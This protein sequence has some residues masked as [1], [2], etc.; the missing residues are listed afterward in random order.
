MGA[1]WAHALPAYFDKWGVAYILCKD[2]EKISR[3]SGGFDAVQGVICHHDAIGPA[4]GEDTWRSSIPPRFGGNRAD[5][6]VGNGCLDH[7]GVFH[8]WAAGAA[9]TAGK[10]GPMLSSRG[11]IA[12]DN[13]N[14]TTFNIE[15]RNNGQGE[16]WTDAQI[17]AYPLLVAAVI[18]WA[19]NETPG[20]PLGAG[21]VW[22]HALDGPGWTNRKI[23]PATAAGAPEFGPPRNRSGTWDMHEF[24]GQV[25]MH[26]MNGPN[27][28]DIVTD[29]DVQ[30]IADAVWAKVLDKKT[31][32]GG[33]E[34][35]GQALE[36][37]RVD[38]YQANVQTKTA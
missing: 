2:W 17:A 36:W 14:R 7:D 30:R 16:P 31:P 11:V 25:F 5:G 26:L 1:I 38:A 22:S 24:R 3:S 9:N 12:L 32:D 21:D 13:A 18:D 34:S 28:E 10:G 23:D 27:Q 20:K 15:A 29:E 8:F 33:T 6:P 4:A 35:T 19:N 37:L